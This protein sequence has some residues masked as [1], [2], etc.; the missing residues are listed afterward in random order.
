MLKTALARRLGA[1]RRFSACDPCTFARCS[2]RGRDYSDQDRVADQARH[3][4]RR[5]KP[6]LRSSVRDL[7]AEVARRTRCLNLL[8]E[9]I[10]KADGTPDEN[11]DQAHQ[12]QITSAPN[13][14]KFFI[15]AGSAKKHCIRR[16]RH[17][18]SPACK[19]RRRGHPR[20]ARRRSGPARPPISFC[21][22]PAAP[23]CRSASGP[24][25]RITNVNT[26]AARPVPDDRADHALRR[27]H[28]RHHPPVLPD[29]SAD[30]L[31]DRQA[32]TS[33]RGNPTGCLHDLQSAITT[34][35][36]TAARRH[37]ARYRPDHGVLQHAE[38]RRALSE[39]ARRSIH[40][41]RQLSPAGDGR[42]RT[43]QRAARL[44]RPGVLRRRRTGNAVTPAAAQ[45]L[46]SGS[47]ARHAEPLHD[48]RSS[49][50]TARDPTQ[51]R[52]SSRSS[53]TSASCLTP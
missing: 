10:V 22:A 53:T 47:A 28:R 46:Q 38:G 11:F 6:Q 17:L 41:E 44:R 31:R 19:I 15:S 3:H 7:R 20:H 30:G 9:R 39:V 14:G 45:H 13:G 16:C 29:V 27:L 12:F 25:T 2:R 35:Y 5:R 52:A 43:G 24:D 23:A 42:N 51:R 21:S 1:A 49:G 36:A 50:S 8:S 48:A 37:A 32:S 40:D 33:R 4:H 18:I 26:A 34:T